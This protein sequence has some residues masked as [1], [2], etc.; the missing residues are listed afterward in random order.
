MHAV[1]CILQASSQHLRAAITGILS[2]HILDPFKWRRVLLA[3]LCVWHVTSVS[4]SGQQVV[5]SVFTAVITTETIALVLL[6]LEDGQNK[7]N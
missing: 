3:F 2:E 6:I 7:T 1:G 5:F 4:P